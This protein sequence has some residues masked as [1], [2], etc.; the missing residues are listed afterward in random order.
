[1]AISTSTCVYSEPW[2]YLDTG[3][4]FNIHPLNVSSSVPLSSV[5]YAP[6]LNFQWGKEVCSIDGASS[7]GGGGS[8]DISPLTA[9]LTLGFASIIFF[10]MII[11][12]FKFIQKK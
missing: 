1:M 12:S 7:G 3:N 11:L 6:R 2:L 8:T 5:N 4:D 10:A 9:V